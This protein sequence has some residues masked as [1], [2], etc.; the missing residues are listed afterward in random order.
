[1]NIGVLLAALGRNEE[2]LV[3]TDRALAI[4]RTRLGLDHPESARALSNRG[5]MLNALN[6]HEEAI[7]DFDAALRIWE[8]VFEPK[9][10]D[11]AAALAGL[12]KAYLETDKTEQALRPLERALEIQG[13]AEGLPQRIAETRFA[14]ARALWDSG[15]DRR[16]A[17]DLARQARDGYGLANA[18]DKADEVKAWLVTH[19]VS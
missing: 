2:G 19:R 15:R 1:M 18:R 4:L 17:V 3:S 13:V 16:R 7:T 5:E 12:G 8:R 9:H 10:P 6:R 14:L 11:L